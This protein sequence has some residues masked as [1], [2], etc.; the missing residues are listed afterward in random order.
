MTYFPPQLSGLIVRPDQ[1]TGTSDTPSF[2]WDMSYPA[3]S[4]GGALT[5][6][7]SVP[8]PGS[9]LGSS[10]SALL[11]RHFSSI[12]SLSRVWLFA[13]PWITAL[14]ASLSII[15][16]QSSLR[17]TSIESVMSSSHLIICCPLLLLPSIFPSIRVFSNES[18]LLIR[19]PNNWRF[20]FSISPSNEYSGLIS[21]K[22]DWFDL[23]AVQETLKDLL[24]HHSTKASILQCS[25][26]FMA[27]LSQNYRNYK[28][29]RNWIFNY[30][31]LDPFFSYS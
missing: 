11:G 1:I 9:Y 29:Y 23:L 19:W 12:Q 13:T 8:S 2:P 6:L 28:T 4:H 26:S 21:F 25:A 7:I 22:I 18:F 17:F 20:C 14:Q 30:R 24:Q 16:P 5:G 31:N 27:H 3:K 15:N 10:A